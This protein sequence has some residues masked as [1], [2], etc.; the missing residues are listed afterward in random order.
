MNEQQRI[1]VHQM[2]RIL[3]G[4]THNLQDRFHMIYG[5]SRMA[6]HFGACTPASD[7]IFTAAL[8]I[9]VNEDIATFKAAL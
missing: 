7:E 6:N 4:G 8:N 2:L 5:M 9:Y 1:A 3:G